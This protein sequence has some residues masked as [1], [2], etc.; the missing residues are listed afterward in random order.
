MFD[1]R[2]RELAQA[3]IDFGAV[4][5]GGRRFHVDD[6]PLVIQIERERWMAC[7]DLG[8]PGEIVFLYDDRARACAPQA[9]EEEEP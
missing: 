8:A 3:T 2:Q 4:V 5:D 9:M 6:R 1:L 7:V